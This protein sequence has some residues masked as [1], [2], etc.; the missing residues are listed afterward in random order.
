MSHPDDKRQECR[1][2]EVPPGVDLSPLSF[3]LYRQG[4]PHKIT[5]EVGVQVIWVLSATLVDPVRQ[6]YQDWQSGLLKLTP[7]PE[8]KGVGIKAMTKNIPWSRYPLT[9]LLLVISVLVAVISDFGQNGA[10]VAALNFVPLQFLPTD[11]G[12]TVYLS[13]LAFTLKQ[14]EYWR[15]ITPVLLHFSVLHLV[16]NMMWLF[17]LG[18][19]IE[20]RFGGLHLL[21]LVITSGL[22][23]NFAQYIFGGDIVIFGGFS[24]VI[25]GLLGYC[26]IREKVDKSCH[27]DILPAIYGFMLIF[28][29]VGYTGALDFMLGSSIANAAHTGGLLSGAFIGGLAGILVKTGKKNAEKQE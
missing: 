19:R 15:L 4:I 28:L 9:L 3:F 7:A 6:V 12:T 16:F 18:R 2:L 5:E 8:R 20:A 22:V 10:V 26:M 11:Q 25:Y 29:V 13:S 14:G 24:G 17:D 27:F 21:L 23:S 1:A